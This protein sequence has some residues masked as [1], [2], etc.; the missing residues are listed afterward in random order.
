MNDNDLFTNALYRSLTDMSAIRHNTKADSIKIDY[1][2]N[3]HGYRCNEISNQEILVLGCSQTEGHGLPLELTWPYLLSQKINKDYVNLAKGGDGA[4]AQITKA[5]QFFKEFYKPKYIFALLPL[6]R[7]EVPLFNLTTGSGSTDNGI[8]KA[9]FNTDK[10][11]K[12]SKA[13]HNIENVIPPEFGIF[14]SFLFIQ[15]FIEYCKTNNIKFI[16][17]AYQ[18]SSGIFAPLKELHD[19][20]FDSKYFLGNDNLIKEKCHSE[21]SDHKLFNHAADHGY[22]PLG[23]WGLHKQLHIAESMYN[24]L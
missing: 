14:Y 18:D 12:Y 13:P 16:W 11:L 8:G 4:Q 2:F 24:M 5:F 9:I 19:G 7:L 17:T 15:M 22:W 1:N 6:E 21:F 23:H 10:M 3:S 20:Y